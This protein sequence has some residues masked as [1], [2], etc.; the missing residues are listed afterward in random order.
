MNKYNS[1]GA[2]VGDFLMIVLAIALLVWIADSY[3]SIDGEYTKEVTSAINSIDN[4]KMKNLFVSL[5]NEK[6]EDGKISKYEYAKLSEVYNGWETAKAT[7]QEANY[8]KQTHDK[9][10]PTPQI[11]TEAEIKASEKL[12]KLQNIVLFIIGGVFLLIIVPYG[13]WRGING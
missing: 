3:T 10:F 2:S 8:I 9:L 11:K 12:A 5:V 1:R 7:G 6:M 13:F 4:P